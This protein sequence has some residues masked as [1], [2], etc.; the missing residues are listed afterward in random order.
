M[1]F[2]F[3]QSLKINQ[4]HSIPK[5]YM[6]KLIFQRHHTFAG[7]CTVSH[8]LIAPRLDGRKADGTDEGH[9]L[10]PLVHLFL[11]ENNKMH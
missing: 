2:M 3:E 10:Q 6:S 7:N 4:E 11:C 1:P 9:R 8:V 5:F